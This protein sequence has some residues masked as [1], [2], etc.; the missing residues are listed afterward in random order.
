[1]IAVNASIS[2]NTLM[3][4]CE[5]TNAQRVCVCVCVCVCACVRSRACLRAPIFGCVFVCVAVLRDS[6]VTREIFEKNVII[7]PI[8]SFAG[9]L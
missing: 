5:N 3:L 4:I 7:K 6:N 1:M 9:I 2:T 8:V